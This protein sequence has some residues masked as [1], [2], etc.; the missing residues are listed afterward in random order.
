MNRATIP[1][2]VGAHFFYEG[3]E[4]EIAEMHLEGSALEVL[5]SARHGTIVKRLSL[6]ELLNSGRSQPLSDDDVPKYDDEPDLASVALSAAPEAER[7]RAC[8]RAAHVR[9]VLTGYRSGHSETASIGEPRKAFR[10]DVPVML[11]YAAKAAELKVDPRTIQRWV[12]Q[13]RASGEAGLI[14]QRVVQP[15]IGTRIDPR[16]KETALEVMCEFTDLSTPSRDLV[17]RLTNARFRDRYGAT[18]KLPCRRTAYYILDELEHQQRAL[19]DKSA[20]R[21]RDIAARPTRS[22]GKLHPTRPGEYMLMDTTRLD[23]YAMDPNTLLWVNAEL[24][25]VMDWFTRC[26]VGLRLTPVSTKAIDAAAALYQAFRPPPAGRDW[27]AQAVWPP[28]GVPRSVLVESQV[29]DAQSVIAA[30]TPA[31]V[32]ETLIVDHGK[33]YVGAHLN[34]VC[35]RLGISIQPARLRTG[36]DKG[37]VERFFRT[38]REDLLQA[39]PG[40]K[41]PDVYSRGLS[42]EKDA[43]FFLDELEAII[44]EWI[45]TIYHHQGRKSLRGL[46]VNGLKLSPAEKFRPRRGQG[47]I[48]RSSPGPVVGV[49]IPARGVAHTSALRGRVEQSRLPR[50]GHRRPRR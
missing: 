47:R 40:Y 39:L 30:A 1:V 31:I 38:L 14:S 28:H 21:N 45:A 18:V 6:A 36:R 4:V 15:G 43:W 48:P 5:V 10:S 12:E 16:W 49:G 27:P 9:E 23:V 29:L 7:H 37:P 2:R 35:Q 24:T 19:F 22:Y 46:K 8:E 34:S 32:P 42:P 13:Y 33:I 44:R 20:A 3:E 25:V 41:G 11:R 50:R 17:I 26:I